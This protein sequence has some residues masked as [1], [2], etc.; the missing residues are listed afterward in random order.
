[1]LRTCDLTSAE[2]TGQTAR[3]ITDNGK[4][5]TTAA[6]RSTSLCAFGAL[7]NKYRNKH[8]KGNDDARRLQSRFKTDPASYCPKFCHMAQSIVIWHICSCSA[9]TSPTAQVL[10][11]LANS[12]A[13]ELIGLARQP[14]RLI[15]SPL[16]DSVWSHCAVHFVFWSWVLSTSMRIESSVRVVCV[17]GTSTPALRSA[18]R[19]STPHT[20]P[21]LP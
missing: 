17:I 8:G 14:R 15:C 12:Q 9:Q 19:P 20:F 18:P 5:T 3:E 21:T 1:M 13:T 2:F 6:R 10:L 11:R 4:R 16:C 7:K